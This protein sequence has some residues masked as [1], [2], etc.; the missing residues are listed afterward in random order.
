V[1]KT[2]SNDEE[3]KDI[4]WLFEKYCLLDNE[5]WKI[6]SSILLY[7]AAENARGGTNQ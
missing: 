7:F 6:F 2:K 4:D 3:I 5:R 1:K